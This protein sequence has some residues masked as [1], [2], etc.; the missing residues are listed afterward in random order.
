MAVVFSI[1]KQKFYSRLSF[2][3]AATEK[4]GQTSETAFPRPE[5]T[6]LPWA[7]FTIAWP[8]LLARRAIKMPP[9]RFPD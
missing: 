2:L 4:P 3:N 6:R 8:F 5:K 9:F 1:S 7:R